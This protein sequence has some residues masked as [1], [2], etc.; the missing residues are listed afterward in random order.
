[1]TK[2]RLRLIYTIWAF[3]ALWIIVHSALIM[4]VRHNYNELR[5]LN[6][7]QT[8]DKELVERVKKHY[9]LP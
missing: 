4:S 3:M 9:N 5:K 8:V 6:K 2:R 7:P 1:M